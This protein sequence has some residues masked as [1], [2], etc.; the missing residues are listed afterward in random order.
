MTNESAIIIKEKVEYVVGRFGLEMVDFAI[1]GQGSI[2]IIR[3]LV[4]Y[5]RG[6]VT[7]DKCSCL[8]RAVFSMIE[9]EGLLEGSYTVEVNSPGLNRPLKEEKDFLRAK[10]RRIEVWLKE[11]LADKSYLE[12][13]VS[14]CKNNSVVAEIENNVIRIP[15]KL[16]KAAKH[17]IEI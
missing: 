17:K 7:V 14:D 16:I 10:G 6:G 1:I 13:T 5:P 3:V 11:P 15:F 8:N 4:D 2:K 12:I 9:Q